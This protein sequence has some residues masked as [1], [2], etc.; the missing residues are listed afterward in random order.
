MTENTKPDN[1][2]YI[3][4]PIDIFLHEGQTTYKPFCCN[5]YQ[6]LG[7]FLFLKCAISI[8][9]GRHINH[10]SMLS[11]PLSVVVY[12]YIYTL[13][14]KPTACTPFLAISRQNTVLFP[15]KNCGQNIWYFIRNR[16]KD[17]TLKPSAEKFAKFQYKLRLNFLCQ[18]FDSNRPNLLIQFIYSDVLFKTEWHLR[19]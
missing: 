16:M 3:Q 1:W 17:E 19:A 11:V 2:R 4:Y 12:I 9:G 15:V 18:I 5:M 8:C 7:T 13:D 14:F 6:R 10:Q